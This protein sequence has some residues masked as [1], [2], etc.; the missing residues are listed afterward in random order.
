MKWN[1]VSNNGFN[2]LGCVFRWEN[3]TNAILGQAPATLFTSATQNGTEIVF[4]G[5]DLSAMATGT[6]YTAGAMSPL[7]ALFEDCEINDAVAFITGSFAGQNNR[8]L[9]FINCSSTNTKYRYHL[10][11]Y[12]GDI[13]HEVTIVRSGGASDG[14][15]TFSRK[16]V[17]SA[18]SKWFSPLEFWSDTVGSVT[19]TVPVI[20]DNVTLTTADIALEVEYQGTASLPLGNFVSSGTA[21]ALATGSNY[22]TDNASVWTTTGITTPVQQYLKVTF[23]TAGKGIVRAR[24]KLAKASTTV[25]F[26][27]LTLASSGRQYMIGQSGIVNDK[28]LAQPPLVVARGP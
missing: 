15:T 27:P 3:T 22:G 12:Q 1:V 20:T 28:A 18:N 5:L 9:R 21:D 24:L 19:V 16:M 25:W 8:V 26:D 6:H 13:S 17:T 23:N 14:T 11:A 10:S 2:A 7:N 4:R